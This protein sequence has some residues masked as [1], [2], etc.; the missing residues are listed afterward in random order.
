[1]DEYEY[2]PVLPGEEVWVTRD[3]LKTIPVDCPNPGF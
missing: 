2:I 3:F 1:M